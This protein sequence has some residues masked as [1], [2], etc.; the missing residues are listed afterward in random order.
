MFF[1]QNRGN[2]LPPGC[3]GG[4]NCGWLQQG[5]AAFP[6]RV[7]Q[8]P[9]VSVPGPLLTTPLPS[10]RCSPRGGRLGR[11][12]TA[13]FCLPRVLLLLIRYRNPLNYKRHLDIKQRSQAESSHSGLC[14]CWLLL[15][16]LVLFLLLLDGVIMVCLSVSCGQAL[17]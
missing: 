14:S 13:G 10:P 7:L 2:F 9:S 11:V 5:L 4:Q 1:S 8:S 15:V 16:A 3:C 17:G 6:P 12:C